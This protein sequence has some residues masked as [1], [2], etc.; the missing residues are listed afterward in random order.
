MVI[1]ISTLYSYD[2]LRILAPKIRGLITQPYGGM[3]IKEKKE[4]EI[5]RKRGERKM[6]K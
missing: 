5:G 2:T 6:D 4:N 1:D 3:R